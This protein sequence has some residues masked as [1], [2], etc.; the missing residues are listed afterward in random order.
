MIAAMSF[1]MNSALISAAL[2]L[3]STSH[4]SELRDAL[5]PVVQACHVNHDITGAA[6]PC[7]AVNVSEG[8]DR[9]YVVLRSPT[10]RQDFI[11]APTR[12]IVGIEDESL[13]GAD[14]PNYF[15]DAWNART[16]VAQET[17]GSLARDDVA[18]AVNSKFNRTQDQLHIHI[19][20]IPM[21]LK[22]VINHIAPTLSE[23]TWTRLARPVGGL[24]F[25]ARR[26]DQD[27]LAGVNPFQLASTILPDFKDMQRATIFI[28]GSRSIGGNGGFVVF[29]TFNDLSRP[30]FRLSSSDLLSRSCPSG[31][32]G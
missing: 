2:F 3:V 29:A 27:T 32:L 28:A 13:Q 8:S 19:G 30:G 15:E 23:T 11:L 1:L 25:W 21:P 9:G 7:L 10:E 12:K 18:L 22:D 5:W 6:F 4:S 24:M 26:V 16:I 20:C 14:T 31:D 17:R